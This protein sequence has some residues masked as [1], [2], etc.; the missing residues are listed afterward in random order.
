[1]VINIPCNE[2]CW[3]DITLLNIKN[4]RKIQKL[5]KETD[6]KKLCLRI[7]FSEDYPSKPPNFHLYYKNYDEF[8]NDDL[9]FLQ[10]SIEQ[11]AKALSILNE[12]MIFEISLH[13]QEEYQKLKDLTNFYENWEKKEEEQRESQENFFFMDN[14]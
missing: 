1:M 3:G 6:S 4:K 7:R 8:T 10:Y 5:V 12:P 11:K 2:K 13:L 9:K 14:H